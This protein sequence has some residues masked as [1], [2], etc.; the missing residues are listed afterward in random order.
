M[1][2]QEK[3]KISHLTILICYTIFSV[4][5]VGETIIM[6]WD[7]GAVMLLFFGMLACWVLHI[8]GKVPEEV[9]IWLYYILTM[10]TFFFYGSHETSMYDIA[11]VMI[12]VMLLFSVTE[13]NRFTNFCILTYYATMAYDIVVVCKGDIALDA[14]GLTR[15]MLHFVLVTVS[16]YLIN[17]ILKRRKEDQSVYAEKIEE[18]EEINHR[19]EQFLTNVSHELRTPINAVTGMT[20]VMMKNETDPRKKKDILSIQSAGRRLFQQIEDILDYTELDTGRIKISEENY[21]ISSIVN[22]VIADDRLRERDES[23]ELVFDV[24]ASVPA[25]L[26][27]DGRK[28][29]KMLKHLLDNGIKFTKKGGV[30][31]RISAIYKAYGVNLCIQVRD[32]GIGVS[33]E[34]LDKIREKFYQSQNG[35]MRRA[36]GLGLGLSIVYGMT[37][38]MEGFIQID[39]KEGQGTVVSISIPQKIADDTPCM[40]VENRTEL[41]IACYIK[42]ERYETPEV[43]DYFSTTISHLVQGLDLTLHRVVNQEELGRLIS[44]YRLTHLFVGQPEYEEDPSYFE[45]LTEQ[46]RVIV[47][48]GTDF[49]L[50]RD[51]KISIIRKPFCNLSVANILNV[52]EENK[53]DIYTEKHILCP[54]VRV[55]VVDDEPMNLMVAEGIFKEYQMDVTTAGSGMEAVELCKKETY[56]L[57]FLDHMMPEM[58]GVETLKLLRKISTSPGKVLTV[59]AFTANAVSG[60]REMFRREGFDEF[61]SKPIEDVELERVLK[62]VLPRTAYIYEDNTDMQQEGSMESDGAKKLHNLEKAGIHTRAGMNYCRGDMKFYFEL[63]AKF[64]QETEKKTQLLNRYLEAGDCENYRIQVHSLKSTS[65][66]IGAE[67]F[68]DIAKNREEAAKNAQL[69]YIKKR[70]AD[71]LDAYW[72]AARDI[73]DCLEL[74]RENI[75]QAD[76]SEISGPEFLEKLQALRASLETFETDK[77]ET[78]LNQMGGNIYL[79]TEVSKLVEQIKQ[80]VEDFD[81]TQGIQKVDALMETVKGGDKV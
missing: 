11:P 7:M 75:A 41:C 63:L 34:Q 35:K 16:G 32:T 38:A 40:T 24:D 81:C 72:S 79:G 52:G 13:R 57:I 70:H 78:L 62:K 14:L 20:T 37:A 55:L 33:A 27:G 3:D 74:G 49:E 64:V 5:L 26:I 15:L 39:S 59:I 45:E 4:I 43:R 10:L 47:V 71:L 1:Y 50:P 25:M 29:K 44:L 28:I 6:G 56:D 18:L 23:I 73:E 60:A 77:A 22:D 54:G 42:P 30:Y 36:G 76:K 12:L 21:M 2:Q 58:D 67:D 66:M 80:D 19:T 68:S 69:E 17:I 46:M 61:V 51:S 48:A 53:G 31:V 9:R 65:K 8:M